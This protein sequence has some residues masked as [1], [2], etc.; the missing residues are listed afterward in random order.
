VKFLK[1][2]GQFW[3]DFIIGDDP[4]I[5][6]AVVFALA[7]LGALLATTSLGDHALTIIG[8][9]LIIASFTA[10]LAIDIRAKGH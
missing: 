10:S 6:V 2:F 4:K 5:A 3:Y 8:G 7:V 9:V 1:S